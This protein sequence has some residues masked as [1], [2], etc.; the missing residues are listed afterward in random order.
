M[1]EASPRISPLGECSGGSRCQPGARPARARASPTE[2]FDDRNSDHPACVEHALAAESRL[3]GRLALLPCAG[4]AVSAPY[5][6]A[7]DGRRTRERLPEKGDPA[8]R[9]L[10]R[11]RAALAATPRD[12]DVAAGVARARHRRRRASPAIR[13]SWARRKR[14]WRRGGRRPMRRRRRC[15]C[16]PRSGRASTISTARSPTSTGCCSANPRAAQ[17]RLTRA[18]V[19]TV[20]GR[21]ADARADCVELAAVAAPLVV[22]GCRAPPASLSGERRAR[23]RRPVARACAARHRCRSAWSGR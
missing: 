11:M 7:D 14:R 21:Y 19:L 18:T 13:A 17:A 9:E 3:L 20:V 22:A 6:P 16:A 8:L 4:S 1:D 5:L 2:R 15:C 10:K 23:V 12:L